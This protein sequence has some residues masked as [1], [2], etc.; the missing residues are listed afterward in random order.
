MCVQ[1]YAGSAIKRGSCWECSSGYHVMR[2]CYLYNRKT[3]ISTDIQRRAGLAAIA[4]RSRLIWLI[5]F[6]CRIKLKIHKSQ[7]KLCYFI[8]TWEVILFQRKTIILFHTR[9]L[10]LSSVCSFDWQVISTRPM[11]SYAPSSRSCGREPAQ[12][13]LT[14]SFRPPAVSRW[15]SE[16]STPPTSFKITSAGSRGDERR[17]KRFRGKCRLVRLTPT[18][19]RSVRKNNA[20]FREDGKRVPD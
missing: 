13:Y 10:G 4:S 15:R 17:N 11:R 5:S 18:T 14:R 19:W 16:G 20:H 6:D 7:P 8:L 9:N 2:L 1:N 3:Y 12:R